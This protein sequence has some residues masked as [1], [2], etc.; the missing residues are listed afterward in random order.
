VYP[1]TRYT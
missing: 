1:V